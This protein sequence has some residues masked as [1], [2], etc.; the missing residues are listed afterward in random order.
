MIPV[1][2]GSLL[3]GTLALRKEPLR[4]GSKRETG[5]KKNVRKC[6]VVA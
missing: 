3:F 6:E 2:K 4:A 1:E 5:D